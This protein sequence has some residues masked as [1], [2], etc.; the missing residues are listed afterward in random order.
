MT[1]Q[2]QPT[3]EMPYSRRYQIF[4]NNNGEYVSNLAYTDE[5]LDDIDQ[6]VFAVVRGLLGENRLN[7]HITRE[8]YSAT[9]GGN[10]DAVKAVPGVAQTRS[11]HPCRTLLSRAVEPTTTHP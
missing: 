2:D 9:D 1:N 5:Q 4:W 7:L 11:D 6:I 10:R 8:E 3:T